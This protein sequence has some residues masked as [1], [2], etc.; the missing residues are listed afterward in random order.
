MSI[1]DGLKDYDISFY[2]IS[3]DETFCWNKDIEY[4]TDRIYEHYAGCFDDISFAVS[5]RKRTDILRIHI[6]GYEVD[7][8]FTYELDKNIK[9]LAREINRIIKLIS[10]R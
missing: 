10:M 5:E 7:Y 1:Y 8:L 3:G 9:S 4:I 6:K 2:D